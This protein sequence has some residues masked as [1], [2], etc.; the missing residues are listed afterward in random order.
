MMSR[1]QAVVRQRSAQDL[2]HWLASLE[3][4]DLEAILYDWSFW[5]RPNQLAPD[6]DW[7][8]WLVLAGRGFGKTRMGSE[9]VR[10]LVEG[11]TALSA[12]AGA[13]ARIAWWETAL[14]MCAM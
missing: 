5:A 4:A 2:Q 11:P 9:W 6:G 14:P 8:C 7:F 3:P 13:P 12:K 1:A 10:S